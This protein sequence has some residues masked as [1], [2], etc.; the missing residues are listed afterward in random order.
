MSRRVRVT[1][2]STLEES[3]V[4]D[5]CAATI[6]EPLLAIGPQRARAHVRTTGHTVAL[7]VQTVR[8]YFAV[9]E[10][11]MTGPAPDQDYLSEGRRR[12]NASRAG[13]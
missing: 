10:R 12:P 5:E 11:T 9:T 6:Y 3:V 7:V 13:R 4:C 8:E 1:R 2:V